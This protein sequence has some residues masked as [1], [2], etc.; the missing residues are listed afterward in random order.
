[1]LEDKVT[2][3]DEL[4]NAIDDEL[5]PPTLEDELTTELLALIIDDDYP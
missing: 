1:M 4:M 5:D 2:A 3:I